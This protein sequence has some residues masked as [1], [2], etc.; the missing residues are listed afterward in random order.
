[1]LDIV[2]EKDLYF[3]MYQNMFNIVIK[4][5]LYLIMCENKFKILIEKIYFSNVMVAVYF[6]LQFQYVS[7]GWEGSVADMK[8]YIWT[9]D[10]GGFC[11]P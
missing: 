1:M 10:H 9:L 3:K 4:K 7:A 6:H 11:V 8:I 5:D 2:I